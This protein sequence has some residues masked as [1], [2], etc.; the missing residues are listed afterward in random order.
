MYQRTGLSP[1]SYTLRVVAS[2]PHTAQRA[3]LRGV[4]KIPEKEVCSVTIINKRAEVK[5]DQAI[6]EFIGSD[7]VKDF[8][9]RTD[10]RRR[11]PCEGKLMHIY[12]HVCTCACTSSV[13]SL[14]GG[15]L[16]DMNV[17]RYPFN[18]DAR[19]MYIT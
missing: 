15:H 10:N 12:S 3:V 11:M 1:R 8:Q 13:E 18:R 16:W 7:S 4:F 2:V 14:Y 19:F 5:G 6:V 9:C 17:L